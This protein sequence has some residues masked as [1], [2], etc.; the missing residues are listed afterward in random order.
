MSWGAQKIITKTEMKVE[1]DNY[2]S[3][4]GW[5][6]SRLTKNTYNGY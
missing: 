2:P 6:S 1:G 3:Q 4:K 5:N